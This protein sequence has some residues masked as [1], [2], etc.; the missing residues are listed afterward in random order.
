[1]AG[2]RTRKNS[3]S[4]T[5]SKLSDFVGPG[6]DFLNSEAPTFRSVI[7]R[8]ILIKENLLLEQGTA[9]KDIHVKP[10]VDLLIPLIFAQWQK[11]NAKFAPPVTIREE[12]VG[13]K[14]ERF[15]VDMNEVV[16]GR[17][18]KSKREK[19]EE[20]LDKLMDIVACS[21]KILLC[22]E[23][24][25]DCMDVKQCKQKVHI[26]C[27]CAKEKK[28]PPIELEWLH[29]QR[30][31][32]GEKSSMMMMTEDKKETEKQMRA[33][34]RILVEIEAA[35]KKQRKQEDD[36]RLLVQARNDIE[37]ELE[38]IMEEDIEEQTILPAIP[39]V[40][41]QMDGTRCMV[42]AL[43]EERLGELKH[44]ISTYLKI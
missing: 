3:Q 14:V 11:S 1:M 42:D 2:V 30:I 29:A 36:E 43:L 20:Q 25:S 37:S 6:K 5:D 12:S 40:K 34:K 28:V 13:K 23:P 16:W 35:K 22:N 7:Q 32:R 38:D 21:H 26:K 17:C 4:L 39:V 19:V 24:G 27:D 41:E 8:G 10:I 44:S 15:W 31:K 9:K 33:E 18:T